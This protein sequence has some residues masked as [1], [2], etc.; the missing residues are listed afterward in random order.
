M[1]KKAKKPAPLSFDGGECPVCHTIPDR[2]KVFHPAFPVCDRCMK[3]APADLISLPAAQRKRAAV[4]MGV[5]VFLELLKGKM[6]R[7]RR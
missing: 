7:R 2:G 5:G 6:G 4:F 3:V 1:A